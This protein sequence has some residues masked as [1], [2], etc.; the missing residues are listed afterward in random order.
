MNYK[1]QQILINDLGLPERSKK[2]DFI[3]T[4]R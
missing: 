1:D 4:G 2:I 3:K